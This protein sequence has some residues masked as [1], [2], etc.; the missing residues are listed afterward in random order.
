MTTAREQHRDNILIGAGEVYLDLIAADGTRAGERYLGDAVSATLGI[1]TEETT[2]FSG[3][4]PVAE[5][6]SR[7]VR[8]I[9]RQFTLTLHDISMENLQLFVIGETAPLG[10]AVADEVIAVAPGKFFPLGVSDDNPA[11]WSR[12]KAVAVAGGTVDN[13]G[14]FTPAGNAWVA[15]TDYVIEAGAGRVHVLDTAATKVASAAIQVDYTPDGMRVQTTTAQIKAA[16]RYIETPA[17]GAGRNFYAPDCIV[18]PN[19]DLTLLDGRNTE[20]Q[21]GLTVAALEPAGVARAVY[22]DGVAA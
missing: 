10:A 12:V 11:G 19:G 14:N 21:I 3:T 20:Q 15:G 13:A 16:F 22:I 4:G 17:D 9:A 5:E 18:R 1:V 2:V 7:V 8:Q 6:L